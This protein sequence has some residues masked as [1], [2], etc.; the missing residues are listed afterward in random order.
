MFFKRKVK[1]VKNKMAYAQVMAIGFFVII[2][3]GT[4]LLMLPISNQDGNWCNFFD[5]MFTATSAT[6]VTGLVVC[7]TYTQWTMFGQL[8]ILTMIQIGGL[9]FITISVMF[10]VLLKKKIGLNIRN[11]IQ[12]S[13]SSM[14]LSGV[15]KLTKNIFKGTA[16]IEGIGALFLATR[17]VPELGFFTGIYYAVFH[18][19]SAFCNAGFDLFGRFEQYSSLTHFS[20]DIV[21]NVTIM[22][23]IIT[24]GLGFIVWMEVKENK[25]HF[26]KYSL[27]SKIVIVTNL[28]LI[29]GGA[30]LF[31]FFEKDNLQTGMGIYDR[32]L[33][34]LFTSVSART[35]GF[36]TLDLANLTDA[37]VILH[38]VLMFIGGNSGSTAGGIKTTTFVV[39]VVYIWSN[40]RNASGCNIFGRRIGDEDIKK[41][42]MV[43]GLNLGLAVFALMAICASQHLQMSDVLMEVF[44]AIGTVGLSTGITRDLNTFSLCVLILVMYCGRIGSMTFAITL[45][46]KRKKEEVLYPEEHINV[47]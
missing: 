1:K 38:L 6:C 17:F 21:V 36:N 42:N 37:S 2:A 8:V 29:F 20:S 9:G 7:D 4:F 3:I 40:I 44:S 5:A 33:S 35:A 43:L 45:A 13:V 27:H 32:T 11:L 26:S 23:L 24:G 31:A 12:E 22:L 30:T 47:G 19:I 16:I 25:F 15:V 18:S 28:I 14:Q 46:F 10:S 39:F 41:A 34:S